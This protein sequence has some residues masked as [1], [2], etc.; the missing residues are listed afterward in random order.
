MADW[1]ARY[2]T[3]EMREIF[4]EESKLSRWLLVE[5][6][7]AQVQGELGIIPKSA[8][9]TIKRNANTRRVNP[10]RVAEIEARIDHDLLA[11]VNA[12]EEASGKKWGKYV[13]MGVT[14]YD[15][16]DTATAIAITEAMGVIDK[17]LVNLEKILLSEAIRWIGLPCA[18]RTHG[19][20]A[21]PTTYGM[22]F[23]LWAYD[24]YL[25]IERGRHMRNSTIHG[26]I[27]GAVGTMAAL[28]DK[29]YELQERV[30]KR[31]NIRPAL[32]S[33][34]VVQRDMVADAVYLCALTS[35]CIEKIAKEIRN[36]QRTE[37]GE[38]MEP[39]S[40]TQAGSSTMPHKRNPHR[41]ERLCSIARYLRSSVSVAIENVALE[42]ERDL[43]NSANERIILPSSFTLLDYSIK[44][45]SEILSRLE[46]NADMVKRNLH[47]LNGVN[48]AERILLQLVKSGM[49]REEAYKLTKGAAFSSYEKNVPFSDELLR[50]SKISGALGSEAI[51]ELTNPENYLGLSD[52]IVKSA[53]KDISANLRI[54][55]PPYAASR[56]RYKK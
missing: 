54:K 26:K 17:R 55:A 8:A 4:S 36:L 5:G 44:E 14:S 24:I 6:T 23:A 31:L 35:S 46:I 52:K 48:L 2:G 1:S 11:L 16:E 27:S 18:G 7:V 34:Q 47:M 15:I 12:L 49:G 38:V 22:K 21:V 20:H 29:G 32:V 37:I 42:H 41:S 30:L 39:F 33:N 9:D 45:I 56:A 13:H 51:A 40:A 25:C 3:K 50:N 43:T 53:V 28:G 10:K 19:Q